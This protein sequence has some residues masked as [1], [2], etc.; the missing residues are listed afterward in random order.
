[1]VDKVLYLFGYCICLGFSIDKK[2]IG[3]F[4]VDF[5]QV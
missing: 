3:R 4:Y 2:D 5:V 1:M